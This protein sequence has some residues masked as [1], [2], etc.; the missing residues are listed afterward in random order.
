MPTAWLVVQ[1]GDGG[2]DDL[3]GAG[4]LPCTWEASVTAPMVERCHDAG[5]AVNVWTCDDPGRAIELD[6]WGVDGI[7]TDVPDLILEALRRP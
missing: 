5:L 7:V 3:S 2:G 1:L 6:G 4:M